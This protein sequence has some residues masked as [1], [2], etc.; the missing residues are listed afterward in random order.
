MFYY[1]G[2]KKRLAGRYPSPSF[3]RIVEPFA[4]SG[5][6]SLHADHWEREV[7][8]NERDPEIVDL[9]RYLQSA[10]TRDIEALPQVQAGDRLSHHTQL[11]PPERLLISL[12][13]GPGKNRQNDVVSKFSR[14]AAGQRYVAANLHKI[15]H[16]TIS[17]GDFSDTASGP[18]TYFVDPPY[19]RSGRVYR[20]SEIDFPA[21]GAWCKGLPGQVIVCEQAGAAWLPFSPL[22][23]IHVAGKHVSHETVWVKEASPTT[24]GDHHA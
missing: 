16:W 10:T 20:F 19:Q 2:R 5:A 8:L 13:A 12:H 22:A 7:W 14:W 3:P 24:E 1:F 15:R 11:T 18:A 23:S 21:L 6:Y 17:C 9:W 4:G